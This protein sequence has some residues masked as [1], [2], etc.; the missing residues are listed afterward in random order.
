MA[1]QIVSILD[2]KHSF[3]ANLAE[4]VKIVSLS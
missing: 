3:W 1:L 4:K 2:Q